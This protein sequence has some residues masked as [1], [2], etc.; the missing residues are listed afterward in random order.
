MQALLGRLQLPATAQRRKAV[1]DAAKVA[2]EEFTP[3]FEALLDRARQAP[4]G[5]A[6]K[7]AIELAAKLPD[8]WPVLCAALRQIPAADVPSKLPPELL[9]VAKGRAEVESLLD[10]WE[11]SSAGTLRRAVKEARSARP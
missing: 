5:E 6:M 4:A 2:A 1:G 10:E 3:L 9:L 8:I 7:S 11:A